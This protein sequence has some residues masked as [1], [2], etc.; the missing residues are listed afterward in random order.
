M[1]KCGYLPKISEK[2]IL[3]KSKTD[4]VSRLLSILQAL[5]MLSQILGRLAVKL[6]ITLLEVNTLAHIACAMIIYALWWNKPKMVNEPTRLKGEWAASIC[7]YM[8]MSSQISGWRRH[9]PGILKKHWKDPELSILTFNSPESDQNR[10]GIRAETIETSSEG[11]EDVLGTPLHSSLR[12]SLQHGTF[13]PR[14]IQA[15]AEKEQLDED[16]LYR[17]LES[18]LESSRDFQEQRWAL[19][20]KAI[21]TYP[22]IA[23]RMKTRHVQA[24]VSSCVQLSQS[25]QTGADID[26]PWCNNRFVTYLEPLTEELVDDA[27]GNWAR[28]NLL[29]NVSGFVMGMILWSASMA[30]GGIHIAAWNSFFPTPVERLLWRCS[31][32][33]IAASGL[34]WILINMSAHWSP[35]IKAYWKSVAALRA[36]IVSLIG[37]GGLA[38]LCGFAYVL[39][40][41]FLVVESLISLRVLP[42]KTFETMQW[43]QLVPHLR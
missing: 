38:T 28:E 32:L 1:V 23:S 40:R 20:A 37:L 16:E 41:L 42:K 3:D 39:A 34:V 5:W 13:S 19:A 10:P 36:D 24:R 2:D 25:A 8:Y 21:S 27:I 4:N 33:C 15:L 9:R 14:P 17:T 26:D 31:A 22:A 29:R 11:T 30:Y 43:T 35:A 6:P 12:T 18:R 7:S